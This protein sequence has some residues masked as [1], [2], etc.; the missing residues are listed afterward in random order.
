LIVVHLFQRVVNG[1]NNAPIEATA[2]YALLGLLC[3][4]LCGELHEDLAEA[5]NM[6]CLTEERRPGA[7]HTDASAIP[8]HLLKNTLLEFLVVLS[9]FHLVFYKQI[10]E[11]KALSGV[12]VK[13]CLEH[14][15]FYVGC[16]CGQSSQALH[17]EQRLFLLCYT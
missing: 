15:S 16:R 4:L 12:V 8:I 11:H 3:F 6:L 13:K 9:R 14:L 5:G 1:I 17:E 10:P 2:I 7:M